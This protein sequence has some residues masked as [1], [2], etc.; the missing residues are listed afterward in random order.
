MVMTNTYY[1]AKNNTY[2]IKVDKVD[3]S[4]DDKILLFCSSKL[5]KQHVAGF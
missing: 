5:N 1:M 2:Y 4:S 3:Q